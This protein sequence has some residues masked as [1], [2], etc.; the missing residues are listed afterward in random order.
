MLLVSTINPSFGQAIL[1]GIGYLIGTLIA[2]ILR[3]LCKL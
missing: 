3:R 2:M 1:F